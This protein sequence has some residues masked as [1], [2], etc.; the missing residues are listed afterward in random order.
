MIRW[1]LL[2]VVILVVLSAF[3]I[4]GSH[5]LI[6]VSAQ[7]IS[8]L[9]QQ[10]QEKQKQIDDLQ[11][12]LNAS[13]KQENTLNSQLKFIDGQTQ[14]TQLKVEQTQFQITKLDKEIE[15]LDNRIGR[16]ST[17]VDQLSTVLL[18]RIVRTYKYSEVTPI[19]L[20]FSSKDISDL[21][22]RIKY[23]QVV[24]ANDKK[25]LYQLQA[26]KS[27]YNDQKSDKQTRQAQAESLKKDLVKY[28]DQLAQQQTEKNK[29]LNAVKS[30]EAKYQ[31]RIRDLQREISQIQNAANSLISTAPRHVSKGDI[32]GLMGNTGY[33]TGAHLHFGVYDITSLSQYN[34]YANYENPANVLKSANVKWY[35]YPNCDDSKATVQE[36]ATGSGSF[37]W[38]MDT[39]NLFISQGFGDTCFS[40]KLY[41]GKPHPALDMY[42]NANIT[43]RAPEEGQA[44]FC[45]NCT[46]DGANGVFLF[47]PNGKMT[48]YWH[49]Q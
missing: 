22:S 2:A 38:P 6:P 45:R 31:A 26:T 29:L 10:L 5:S 23:I 13:Q 9:D 3:L 46:G 17:S 44:Y 19:E 39:S 32:I 15:D 1:K 21:L 28:Q 37:D 36:R 43:I 12:Q 33:S 35:D 27:T 18:D 40:G 14:L 16:L 8:D 24:Q 34:Y 7:S 11:S 25:V 48:L 41:G 20:I 30:D 4:K 47:H 42:N 49:L